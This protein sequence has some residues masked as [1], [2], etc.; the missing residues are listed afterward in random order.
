[1]KKTI[2][3]CV[4]AEFFLM[5]PAFAYN[6]SK[7][8]VEKQEEKIAVPEKDSVI[9]FETTPSKEPLQVF[10]AKQ[11]LKPVLAKKL[12]VSSNETPSVSAEPEALSKFKAIQNQKEWVAKLKKQLEGETSQL[13]EMMNSMSQSFRLDVKKLENDSYEFDSK[14]GKFVEK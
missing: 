1:M 2:L 5:T 6:F 3:F 10:P 11:A 12:S 14:S 9:P 13:Q 7:K 8:P 4:L